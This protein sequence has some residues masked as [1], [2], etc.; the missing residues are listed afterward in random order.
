[1]RAQAPAKIN[2]T[3][4]VLGRRGD[5]YHE[6]RSIMQTIDLCDE[7]TVAL[8]SELSL[9]VPGPNEVSE[10]DLV[11]RAARALAAAAG[12][13]SGARI[14]LVKRIPVAAGLGGGSSDAATALRC[15][16][17]L[18]GCGLREGELADIG[19]RVG[20]DV[21]FF[22]TG[23]TALVE[24][25][26]EIVTAL[27]DSPET[28]IVVLAPAL[29]IPEKTKRVFAALSPD[30]FSDGGRTTNYVER[31]KTDRRAGGSDICNVFERAAEELFPALS[32]YRKELLGAG[33]RAV[34]LAGAGPAIFAV[35]GGEREARGVAERARRTP[36]A[37]AY[38]QR[39]LPAGEATVITD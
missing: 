33:A 15:L 34:H 30:D 5:G 10:D 6:I 35:M 12:A 37:T 24:G 28:W 25:R 19:A 3:L 1:M 16:N 13:G 18:W 21:P 38:V 4:E 26:G 39:T 8:D 36:G 14:R 31:L 23:G 9:E 7:L 20:S 22:L 32:D 27:P 2:W 29:S 11:L 17:R